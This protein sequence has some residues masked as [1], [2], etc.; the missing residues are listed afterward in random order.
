V[1]P[2][3]RVKYY[4]VD[5]IEENGTIEYKTTLEEKYF[6]LL[7][8]DKFWY[9]MDERADYYKLTNDEGGTISTWYQEKEMT[10]IYDFANTK[11]ESDLDVY[12][13]WKYT[14][15]AA[16]VLT[17]D[18][19]G[20]MY[21]Y[22]MGG[23]RY[24]NVAKEKALDFVNQYAAKV[25]NVGDKRLLAI[26]SFDTDAKVVLNWVDVNSAEGLAAAQK[27][28]NGMKVA[29]NGRASSN[30]VCTNFDGG[31]ILTRNLL[32]QS[33]VSDIDNKFA[34]VLSDGAPTV[35]V[36][37]DS[38]TVGTIK[39]SFWGKQLDASGKKYQNARAGG[40][41]TH[42]GEVDRTLKYLVTGNNTL[43]DLT[44][45]Y[46]ENKEGIFFIG[47][48]GDMGVKLF[49]DAVYGTSNGTR[50]SDVKRKPAAFNNIEALEGYTQ[51]Q[52]LKMTTGDWLNN[53][54]SRTGGTYVSATNAAILQKEFNEILNYIVN[55]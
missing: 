45:S 38:D 26:A 20:T 28:I 37:N 2:G 10:N 15:E 27:A 24:V 41:W 6:H 52:I 39:S 7:P 12:G 22:K 55:S 43:A 54:A 36:N 47:V 23:T 48:G 46:G 33:A 25:N 13:E 31:I 11:L 16:V 3:Y 35:T 51:A 4:S 49:N 34:I 30:Q 18:M 40:G 9:E 5:K 8:R 42:P 44:T 53:L 29:D 21:R 50:T 17:I 32:K 14:D 19:S 1:V